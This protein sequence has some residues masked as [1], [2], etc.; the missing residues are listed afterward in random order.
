[1]KFFVSAVCLI[2]Y[3]LLITGCETYEISDP[4]ETAD[5]W[6]VGSFEQVGLSQE[7][8][9]KVLGLIDR[10][11][12]GD[13][14][15]LLLV[16]DG[17]LV[18][19]EYFPGYTW[20]YDAENFRG[21]Y[22]EFDGDTP[23]TIMS[24]T[25]AFTS[26]VAGIAIDQGYIEG[27]HEKVF[28]FFPD[29]Q[30][31]RTREKEAITVEH[32]LTMSSGLQWNEWEYPLSDTRN[33]LIRL[34]I[35]DD[36]VVYILSKPL[37]NGPGSSWYYSG[38]DVILLSEIIQQATGQRFDQYASEQLFEP[39][40]IT[41]YEWDFVDEDTVHASGDLM[42]RPRDMA[43]LG[44]LLLNDGRWQGEQILSQSWVE[45]TMGVY[46]NTPTPN[47]GHSYGYQWWHM[48]FDSEAGPVWALHRSG[49]GGQEMY[50]FPELDMLVAM[51]GGY[52]EEE[53]PSNEIVANYII[54]AVQEL[55]V[56]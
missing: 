51:T 1:M 19:E 17:L 25:K 29:Y 36:P 3:L 10:G 23:H 20:V 8:L 38:G 50:L 34:W 52:Y 30:G 37:V 18:I 5:G 9:K 44:Y 24:V 46:I 11:K 54:P 43:K 2:V 56:S 12:Y 22:T 31:L 16:K 47:Q 53:P 41:D 40:G 45:K 27:E 49:W 21:P 33:D 55:M 42:L 15:S 6:A 39:L 35:V 32:L 26:A 7:P 48:T 4:V 28:D 14:H 13:V